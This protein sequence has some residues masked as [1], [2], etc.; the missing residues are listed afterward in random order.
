MCRWADHVPV[1]AGAVERPQETLYEKFKK[2]IKFFI[3]KLQH[4]IS[5]NVI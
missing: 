1:G 2:I 4:S 5:L 3:Q